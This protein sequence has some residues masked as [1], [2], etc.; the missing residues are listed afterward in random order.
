M[1]SG[2]IFIL[3]SPRSEEKMLGCRMEVCAFRQVVSQTQ[4]SELVRPPEC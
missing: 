1:P 4:E 3:R 2:P